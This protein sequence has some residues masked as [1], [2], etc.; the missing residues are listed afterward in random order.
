[1]E[2]QQ[3]SGFNLRTFVVLIAVLV[4]SAC[5]G[6]TAP[7]MDSGTSAE[8][9]Q[10]LDAG[11]AADSPEELTNSTDPVADGMDLPDT[12][13]ADGV[14]NQD[15]PAVE[16]EIY[17]PNLMVLASAA[18]VACD[19][20]V[21]LFNAT[22]L[23]LINESR[24][25]ARQCGVNLRDAV[26]TVTWNALLAEAAVNHAND[27][28]ANNFFSHD[29]SDG[30]NVSKR[31]DAVGYSWRAIGENIAAGQLDQ[32]EVHQGWLDSEGHCFN[33]MNKSFTEVGA[34]CVNDSATDYGNYWVVVFG[35]AK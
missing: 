26:S 17:V 9:V 16:E 29:G 1:M 23:E 3:V 32:A 19:A 2:Y 21:A 31:A 27:M 4:L 11:A 24:S 12:K 35:D 34:A 5:G 8:Q 22:M 20:D 18:D 30:L 10:E 6:A 25:E 14:G 7:K 15:T 13:I 28:V 33:I